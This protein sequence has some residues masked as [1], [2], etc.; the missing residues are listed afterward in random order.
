MATRQTGRVVHHLRRAALLR[1]GAGLTDGQLLECFLHCHDEAAFEAIVRRHG[2]M[3]MGVCR[4]L[5]RHDQDAEDAFQAT[6][7]V[8]V[9]KAAAIASR[10]LLA[11]WLYGVA[12]NTARKA[13]AVAAKRRGRERQVSD[14]PEPCAQPPDPWDDLQPLLDQELSRLPDKYRV[15]IVL[16][17]LQGK[18]RKEAAR[19][20]GWPEGSLSS[21][22]ARG[23]VLLAK[24]LAR[25]GLGVSGGALAMVLTERAASAVVPASVV[26]STVQAATLVAA[27]SAAAVG[28]I[29]AQVIALTEGVLKTMLVS[30]LKIVSAVVLAGVVGLGLGQVT[31]RAA[32]AGPS[33]TREDVRSAATAK[34]QPKQ[35][36]IIIRGIDPRVLEQ[37]A[38]Q[39]RFP[40][41]MDPNEAH[42]LEVLRAVHFGPP[43]DLPQLDLLIR[44]RREAAALEDKTH[45]PPA[46]VKGLAEIDKAVKELRRMSKSTV[47]GGK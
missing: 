36:E 26:V 25:Q 37:W 47:P 11:N 2:P 39:T 41:V 38:A 17:D 34:E 7:L 10:E 8:L 6:F 42:A 32:N 9:R 3:V 46:M 44:I 23:R 27:G 35:G 22:L 16:C 13:R 24:R 43:I 4:R 20:L 31:Y 28:L 29:P 33:P 12:V 1:D 14:M 19:Q 5:L 21:R 30:N 45:D 40:I 18:T 15:P